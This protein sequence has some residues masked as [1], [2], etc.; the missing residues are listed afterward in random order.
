[1]NLLIGFVV[2]LCLLCSEIRT[3]EAVSDWGTRTLMVGLVAMTV[4]GLALFQTM[5]V[6]RRIRRDG[7]EENESNAIMKRI[8]LCH[9][10]VW[11]S[12]SL[13]IIWA[14]RW[15][16]VVRGSWELDRW[17]LVD[18]A[19]I[20]APAIFSLV[21]SWAI[22][23]EVQQT[24]DGEH[25]NRFKLENIKRRIGYVS[26]RFRIYFL[27]VLIPISFAVLTRDLAPWLQQLSPSQAIATYTV[28]ALVMVAGFPFLLLFIWRTSKIDDSELKTNLIRTCTEHRIYVHDIRIWETGNQII[29]A[30]VAGI[31]PRFRVI[32]L[33]DSLVSLF[34]RNELLA[35]LRHEAGH[36]RLWHLPTRIGFIMLPLIALALD[37]K[38]PLGVINGLESK[39]V[40]LGLPS[41]CG[42]AVIMAVYL[43]YLY[44]SM[45]WLSHRMEYEADIYAC[46]VR[47]KDPHETSISREMAKDMSDALLRLASVTP[48]QFERRTIMHPSIRERILLIRDIQAS[49]KKA[50]QFRT[51]FVRRRRIALALLL[52]I[53][54]LATLI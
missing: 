42:L 34:P 53:C 40:A 17:P 10:A 27:M 46:Q 28:S 4:P 50:N 24:F 19:F 48:S 3:A 51:S 18:E 7:F 30:L 38:N 37:E 11:L 49:P 54:V 8:S 41:G 23:Y 15:Q 14:V 21:V 2:L 31:L 35:I 43:V 12:A 39:I 6:S 16:D 29:N 22:F 20:L 52:A 33:S 9:G 47:S 36:L 45:S 13:A 25:G 32:L 44:Y 1:M 26:I 5:V